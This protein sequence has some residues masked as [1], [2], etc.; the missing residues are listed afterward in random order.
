[1][2]VGNDEKLVTWPGPTSGS[3]RDW[4]LGSLIAVWVV[5]IAVVAAVKPV[6][7]SEIALYGPV[8]FLS[9]ALASEAATKATRVSAIVLGIA[10]YLPLSN[11]W[12]PRIWRDLILRVP[13]HPF[14]V[15]L[16]PEVVTVTVVMALLLRSGALR[17]VLNAVPIPLRCG[18]IL[19]LAG[20]LVSSVASGSPSKAAANALMS[21]ALPVAIFFA[22]RSLVHQTDNSARILLLVGL[23]ALL[24]L[25]CG[26]VAIVQAFGVPTSV[27][28][29][30]SLKMNLNFKGDFGVAT[31]GN[32]THMVDFVMVVCP[33]LTV[34]ATL[35][36]VSNLGRAISGTVAALGV[37][38]LLLMFSR[39]AIIVSILWLA[40][41]IIYTFRQR[42]R[43]GLPITLL[44]VIL[45]VVLSPA[46][47]SV[48]G[49]LATAVNRMVLEHTATSNTFSGSQTP[50]R[51]QVVPEGGTPSIENPGPSN[52]G[53]TPTSS[54][55]AQPI[56]RTRTEQASQ[57]TRPTQGAQPNSSLTSSTVDGSDVS[58]EQRLESLKYSRL[59]IERY[60]WLGAGYGQYASLD[61]IYTSPHNL[62]AQVWVEGGLLSFVGLLIVVAYMA[63]RTL[64]LFLS[65]QRS[66]TK[67]LEFAGA[68][69]SLVFLFQGVIAGTNL[70][71][72]G[73]GVWG[74]I[75]GIMVAVGVG[76][77][78]SNS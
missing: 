61:P 76:A 16:L 63:W 15:V 57:A 1:M 53:Q 20:A 24:P 54:P 25:L 47:R 50:P 17:K 39:S 4:R 45:G 69:S 78:L 7:L 28:A 42:N 72:N 21:V 68:L 29:L 66:I 6:H 62:L 65:P 52:L 64:T 67:D 43:P 9:L 56:Q 11:S 46:G 60:G 35:T 40:G 30:L 5:A 36:G 55:S 58:L 51:S 12:F 70:A 38:T 3:W 73:T 8:L 59:L 10:S 23:G 48:Y 14:M 41:L 13:Q 77:R 2:S 32:S 26:M 37:I 22:V 19:M 18:G 34:L 49:S 71:L 27:A 33:A 75:L 74:G 31:F 44:L